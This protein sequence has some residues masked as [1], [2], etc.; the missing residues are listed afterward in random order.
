MR[1]ILIAALAAMLAVPRAAADPIVLESY[2][3]PRPEDADRLLAP[4][5]AELSRAGFPAIGEVERRIDTRLSRPAA[6]MDDASAGEAMRTVEAGYKKYLAGDFNGAVTDIERGLAPLRAAPGAVAGKNDRRHAVMRG[7]LG[8]ALSHRRLG[9]QTEATSAMAELVRSFPD[10]EISYKDYGPE[11]RDFFHKVQGEL[12]REGKGELAIDVDDDKAV[13]FVN[14]R[15]AGVGDVTVKDLYAGRYRVF[16]Q[17]GDELGRVHEVDVEA[18]RAATVTVSW[19]LD[20]ALRAGARL[21]FADEAARQEREARHAVGIARSLGAQSVV[22]LGI[23]DNRGHRSVVG[24]VYPADSM[25][26]LRSG[27][28]AVEPVVPAAERLA[29]LARLLA[30]DEA[31]A[32]L[33]TPLA[34]ARSSG[35]PDDDRGGGGRPLRVWKW[36]AL[37]GGVAAL[38]AGV[39]LIAIHR[40]PEDG[41]RERSSRETRVPGI[42]TTAAGAALS[43]LGVYLF[44]RDARDRR[45]ARSAII[46]P[47]DSGGAAFVFSG[48]F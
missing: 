13:V 46:A 22:V 2:G 26:P 25:R 36:M 3:G 5:M 10:R 7:L 1:V 6:V 14:E 21:L 42:I 44:V 9:R 34:E 12:S 48:S 47:L 38:G 19:Q 8:L 45:A 41:S 4:V 17:Q 39:T 16:L 20:A 27:A 11:P 32:G 43:G 30:G 15:Y 24:A 35:A 40:S 31:A 23:R 28:V 33:V 37:G 29:A 18:G